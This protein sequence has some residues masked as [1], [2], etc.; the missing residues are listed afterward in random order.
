MNG[1]RCWQ[2]LIAAAR[3]LLQVPSLAPDTVNSPPRFDHRAQAIADERPL[4]IQ[5]LSFASCYVYS[6][7]G[8]TTACRRSRLLR[9]LLKAGDRRFMLKYAVRVREQGIA[10]SPIAGFFTPSTVLVPIPGSAPRSAGAATVAGSLAQ[11]LVDEGLGHSIWPGLRRVRAVRKSGT[12][13][14][15]LRPTVQNHYDSFAV[16]NSPLPPDVLLVDDIVTKG[17]TLLAAAARLQDACPG[18]RIRAF[19]LVRT[20]GLAPDVDRL[21]DPCVGEIT[22]RAGDA[23]RNP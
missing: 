13:C 19:A 23:Y 20:M 11:A 22:W 8:S 3:S 21:L 18:A 16:E 9:A 15:G 6:P 10:A 4:V 2:P 1:R 7:S 5:V 17:R 12:A 14:P